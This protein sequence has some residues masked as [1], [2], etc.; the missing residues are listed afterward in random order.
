MFYNSVI[1]TLNKRLEIQGFEP[2]TMT[3][4]ITVLP[5]KLY[6]LFLSKKGLEP[7]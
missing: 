3:C 1:S 6:P 7:L 5:I 2:R 4:K